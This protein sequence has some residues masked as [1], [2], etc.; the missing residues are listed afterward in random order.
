MRG[1]RREAAAADERDAAALGLDA[2]AR[3]RVVGRLHEGFL[4]GAHLQGERALAGLGEHLRRV[5][6]QP[7]LAS[8]PSLSSPQAASTTASRPRS[9][10]LRNRVSM[11]PRS[12]S[13]ESVGSSASSCARRRTEAVPMR[14]PG[15]IASAPHSASRGS[16]RG[17]VGADREPVGVGRGHVLG[18]VDGDVDPPLEQRLLELLDEDAAGSD[19]AEGPRAIAVARSGDRHERDLDPGPAQPLRGQLSLGESEPTAAGADADQHSF[20]GRRA[21]TRRSPASRSAGC[22]AGCARTPSAPATGS[23]LLDMNRVVIAAAPP[24]SRPNRCFTT[25]A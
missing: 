18:R 3:L 14:I 16:S 6:A 9:P 5:E 24:L 22:S 15:R 21:S 25:S 13:I 7:D 10:R 19:L 4:A 2:P 17:R 1:D 20:A 23:G 8:S 11:L 12:G